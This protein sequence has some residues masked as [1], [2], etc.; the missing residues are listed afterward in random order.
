MQCRQSNRLEDDNNLPLTPWLWSGFS[1]SRLT[2][3]PSLLNY[4]SLYLVQNRWEERERRRRASKSLFLSI[5]F[6]CLSWG[7][8]GYFLHS[9]WPHIYGFTYTHTRTVMNARCLS[10]GQAIGKS[11]GV[12]LDQGKKRVKFERGSSSREE[13]L[14]QKRRKRRRKC[15]MH[16]DTHMTAE[17]RADLSSFDFWRSFWLS[18]SWGVILSLF[19]RPA[20]EERRG[21]RF[22]VTEKATAASQL[23]RHHPFWIIHTLIH[24]VG[25]LFLSFI[26]SPLTPHAHIRPAHFPASRLLA[27]GFF[28]PE[29]FSLVVVIL[30]VLT[31]RDTQTHTR[32]ANV[33]PSLC[34]YYSCPFFISIVFARRGKVRGKRSSGTVEVGEKRTQ[35]ER[36]IHRKRGILHTWPA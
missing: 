19:F 17:T 32:V 25:R 10:G 20:L 12:R 29:S 36:E 13:I 23:K 30:V 1:F 2:F 14:Q 28:G 6:C 8:E 24:R 15:T 5:V 18:C 34:P 22:P 33:P 3:F 31:P 27:Q 26:P 21:E 7:E 16:N 35:G 11:P 9:F 4:V